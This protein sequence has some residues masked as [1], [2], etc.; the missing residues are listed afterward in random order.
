MVDFGWPNLAELHSTVLI[1]S[2]VFYAFF[3]F[4]PDTTEHVLHAKEVALQAHSGR[5]RMLFCLA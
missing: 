3:I 5:L 4:F 2:L 1:L